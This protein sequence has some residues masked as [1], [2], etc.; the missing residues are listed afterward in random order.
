MQIEMIIKGLVVD[1]VTNMPIV[2]LRDR[3]GQRVLPIWVG[4]A[5][6]NAI[7]LQIENVSTPRPMTHDLLKNVIEDLHG[8]IQKI[9]VCDLKDN[10]FYALLHLLVNGESVAIDARPSDAIALALRV[11]AP[12]FV[13]ES[14]IDEAKPTDVALEKG[15]SEQLQQWLESLDAEELGKYKM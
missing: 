1:P 12:I 8:D 5:E 11:K 14:V 9:V 7:A 15:D 6:A 4:S 13:E 3:D 2:I 10:T